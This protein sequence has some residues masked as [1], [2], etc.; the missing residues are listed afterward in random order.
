MIS[1]QAQKCSAASS[2]PLL[3]PPVLQNVL[4]YVG[5]GHCLFVATVSR[6][7]QDIYGK[8]QSQPLAIY[9]EYDRPVSI[10]TCVPQMTLYSSVFTS[11]SRVQLAHES[12]LDCTS[13][14]YQRAAGTYADISTLAAA[15]K[16]GMECTAAIMAAAAKRDELAVVQYLHSEGC[17][18]AYT[19]LETACASGHY[20]LVRWCHE[21]DCPWDDVAWATYYATKSGNVEL[22]A[23]ILQQPGASLS[24]AVMSR[25]ASKGHTAMCQYLHAQ[26]CPWDAGSTR[27]AARYGHAE[28]LRWLVDR[29][30][31]TSR[32]ARSLCI[33]AAQGGSL[34]VLTHLQELGL[35]NS[36]PTLTQLLNVAASGHK[37]AVAKWLRAQ[38]A[39]WPAVFSLRP[40]SGEVLAWARA[41]GCTTPITP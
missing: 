35:L 28:L 38:G 5:P 1:P 34:K 12:G 16:L 9:D 8:L 23:W 15:R 7:W 10:I 41:E 13:E 2:S 36:A 32:N 17:P 24:E 40:W 19:L 20:E 37:L 33:A 31:P 22:M 26:Q 3:D 29:G 25:A 30:C 6:L 21:H 4:S 39:E 18:W 27:E 11:P 14:A